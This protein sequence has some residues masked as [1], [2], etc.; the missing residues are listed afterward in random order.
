[1]RRAEHVAEDTCLPGGTKH[2]A[3]SPKPFVRTDLSKFQLR[4]MKFRVAF[5]GVATC[6]ASTGL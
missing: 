6:P 4:S 5:T 3:G 2:P 1:M